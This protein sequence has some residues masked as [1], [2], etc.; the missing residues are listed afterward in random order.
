MSFEEKARTMKKDSFIAPLLLL[1]ATILIILE[2][3]LGQ[4][5]MEAVYSGKKDQPKDA[6]GNLHPTFSVTEMR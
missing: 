4:A 3:G 6:V 1:A 2:G 5:W